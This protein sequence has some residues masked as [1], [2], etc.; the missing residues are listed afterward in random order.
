M[1]LDPRALQQDTPLQPDALAD[2]A[3]RANDDVGADRR[4]RVDG[5][6]RVDENIAGGDGRVLGGLGEL[7]GLLGG[8]VGEV[9]AG[10]GEVVW[11]GRSLRSAA[12]GL[13]ERDG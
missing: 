13:Q 2:G 1:V 10:T 5:R 9:E 4:G 7:G 8:E 6:G 12:R 3:T 11:T